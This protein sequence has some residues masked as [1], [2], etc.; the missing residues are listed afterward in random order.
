M[1]TQGSCS[2]WQNSKVSFARYMVPFLHIFP[3]LKYYKQLKNKPHPRWTQAGANPELDK[4][5][6]RT[7]PVTDADGSDSNGS[8]A[9]SSPRLTAGHQAGASGT[10]T[11]TTSESNSPSPLAFS[12]SGAPPTPPDSMA[13]NSPALYGACYPTPL[14][15][16][17]F[18]PGIMTP[19]DDRHDLTAGLHPHALPPDFDFS[20]MFPSFFP[21]G[22]GSPCNAA[23][24]TQEST[25]GVPAHPADPTM[26]RALRYD[27][28]H[29]G[30]LHEHSIY[31]GMLEFALHLRKAVN[32]LSRSA[33]HQM[34][35]K[36]KLNHYVNQLDA[37]STYV[38]VT[39]DEYFLTDRDIDLCLEVPLVPPNSWA[40]RWHRAPIR[41]LAAIFLY[42]Q[43]VIDIHLR[44]P[45]LFQA[46][47][48]SIPNIGILRQ[49]AMQH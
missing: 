42:F 12:S 34:G 19:A 28:E 10:D 20:S 40:F 25:I 35:L 38:P 33:N 29:C 41:R 6:I 46:S 43:P 2:G 14:S 1:R 13:S 31:S 17:E 18:S 32:T 15:F 9:S 21:F 5:D 39:Y 30:C 11:T 45:R 36:C 26:Q 44:S 23:A 16:D 24:R 7:R 48:H 3:G 4:W 47:G 8:N 22:D 49:W 37:Y 27:G